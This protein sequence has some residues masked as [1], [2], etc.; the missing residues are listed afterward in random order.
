[1]QCLQISSKW[2]TTPLHQGSA[3]WSDEP[4]FKLKL[5]AAILH[6]STKSL[7]AFNVQ[8]VSKESEVRILQTWGPLHPY[9]I[10]FGL[11]LT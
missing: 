4:H 9:L 2:I 1:M 5:S 3:V 10:S 11:C 8:C 7:I 6:E